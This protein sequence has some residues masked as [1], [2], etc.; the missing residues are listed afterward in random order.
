MQLL[1][2]FMLR[3]E[4]TQHFSRMLRRCDVIDHRDGIWQLRP[5]IEEVRQ[6]TIRLRDTPAACLT[7]IAQHCAHQFILD[8]CD[9]SGRLVAS[10]YI[11]CGR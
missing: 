2:L 9:L 11:T 8:G 4:G 10:A 3:M 6:I 5:T 7:R 1:E